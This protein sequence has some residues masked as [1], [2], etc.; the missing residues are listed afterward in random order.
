VLPDRTQADYV[1]CDRNGRALAVIEAKKAAM[2]FCT[3]PGSLIRRRRQ[4]S[5]I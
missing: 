1:L 4:T 5:P 2:C 3:S